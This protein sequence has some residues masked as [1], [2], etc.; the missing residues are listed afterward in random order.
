MA[1]SK[2]TKKK[3]SNFGGDWTKDKLD[4]IEKY[5][6]AYTTIFQKQSWAKTVYIDAFAGSGEISLENATLK[7][8]PLIALQYDFSKYYFIEFDDKKIK[9]LQDYVKEQ[10]PKRVDKVEF[11]NGDCNS[12]LPKLFETLSKQNDVRGVLF[13]DP[14]ALELKWSILEQAKQVK[15]DIFYWFPMM[16]NRLLFKDKSKNDLFRTKLNTL[17]GE[18]NWEEKLYKESPQMNLFGDVLFDKEPTTKLVE[19]IADRLKTLFEYEPS[20]KLF[21]NSHNSLIFL[22]CAMTTNTSEPARKLVKKLASE[23]FNKLNKDRNQIVGD[24]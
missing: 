23:I 4:I 8:S 1:V 11:I 19:Y 5:F 2:Q 10:Y 6:N 14:F 9:K 12:E 3:N 13:L 17:F 7:G 15:L 22:L 24:N 20:I 16:A 18:E 21:K